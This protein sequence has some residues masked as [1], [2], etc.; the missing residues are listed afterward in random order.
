MNKNVLAQAISGQFR[1]AL[2][3]LREA[4]Q[5]FPVEEWRAG[6]NHYLRPAG[7]AYHA[8]ETIDFYTSDRP[9]SQFP[10]GNRFGA[11]WEDPR[12]ELLP[13]QEDVITYLDEIESKLAHWFKTTDLTAPERSYPW[14]GVSKLERTVYMLRHTHHHLAEMCLELSRRGYSGPEWH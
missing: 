2:K 1:R 13:P 14:T 12:S 10:W 6:D 3:M 9:A 4:V 5:A 8:L 7:L 11:D